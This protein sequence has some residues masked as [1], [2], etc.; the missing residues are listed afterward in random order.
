MAR[1]LDFNYYES[2]DEYRPLNYEDMVDV[3]GKMATR[4]NDWGVDPDSGGELA[5]LPRPFYPPDIGS[6]ALQPP[7][8]E[9]VL[10]LAR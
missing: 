7:G 4:E 8:A 9:P 3:L 2:G 5:E 10:G 6:V 1:G